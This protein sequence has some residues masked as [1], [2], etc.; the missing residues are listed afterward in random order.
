MMRNLHRFGDTAAFRLGPFR[1]LQLN[2]PDQAKHVLAEHAQRYTKWRSV[3]RIRPYLGEGLLLA[4]GEVWKRH[5][6]LA[7]PAFHHDRV[8]PIAAQ[9]IAA[10]GEM[11]ARWE[12]LPPGTAVDL[13]AEMM[14][15]ALSIMG[16][17]L[18]SVDLGERAPELGQ[19]FTEALEG[20]SHR[21]LS[22]N[23]LTRFV[24]SRRN[25]TFRSALRL[26]DRTV[27]GMIAERR[28][29]GDAR[30]DVLSMLMGALAAEAGGT[31]GDRL[32]R[33]ELMTLMSAG[34]GPLGYA[35]TWGL[36]LL[37]SHPEV[38]ERL[39][40]EVGVLAGRPPSVEDVPK[41]PY[42]VQAVEEIL[43][44]YPTA[45]VLAREAVAQDEVSGYGVRPGTVILI[46][47]Y[48][49]HRHPEFWEDPERFDPERFSPARVQARRRTAYFPFGYGQRLCIGNNF[50]LMQMPLVLAMVAQRFRLSMVPGQQV[51]AEALITLRPKGAVMARLERADA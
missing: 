14:R 34:R 50:T 26:L 43:R 25:R 48:V 3:Q 24:P 30:D 27:Y 17:T 7:Q 10:T 12:A 15:L 23:P 40:A 46:S 16:R 28:R 1:V 19:A 39:R 21:L 9:G 41:L 4:E 42:L 51:E 49:V 33:D 2:H 29:G 31:G 13:A 8:G 6:R 36:H 45:W 47:P 20:V 38:A 35:L 44:L 18:F 22:L 11:L 37:A 32:L 5:R